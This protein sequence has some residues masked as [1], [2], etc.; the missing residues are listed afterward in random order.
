[1]RKLNSF[2]KLLVTHT[3]TGD[4]ILFNNLAKRVKTDTSQALAS[5]PELQHLRERLQQQLYSGT[6]DGGRH[7]PA[8]LPL[9]RQEQS[10]ALKS[11]SLSDII[12]VL[13][14]GCLVSSPSWAEN[15]LGALQVVRACPEFY[16]YERF[17]FVS[18]QRPK[19]AS[20]S[21]AQLRLLFRA[22]S[23]VASDGSILAAPEVQD[24]ALLHCFEAAADN[25]SDKLAAA[26]CVR[27][28]PDTRNNRPWYE[29][30]PFAMI[31]SREFV[32]KR[33]NEANVYHV[34]SFLPN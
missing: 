17:D 33:P 4:K 27:I 30:V 10:D 11:I 2:K 24:F 31:L 16:G 18:F 14:G 5:L 6:Y 32:V 19:R 13:P 25:A 21:Y 1:M 12:C 7:L 28:K 22:K 15:D 9:S 23:A 26:G 29:V 20:R 3:H 34:S 8:P